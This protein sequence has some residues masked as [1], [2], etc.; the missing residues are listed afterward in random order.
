MSRRKGQRDG[1]GVGQAVVPLGI[2]AG[3]EGR[4]P[5]SR[6]RRCRLRRRGCSSARASHPHYGAACWRQQ[7]A[8]G[9]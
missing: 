3:R 1:C 6:R 2:L 8:T 7:P 5:A 9:Y 4:A